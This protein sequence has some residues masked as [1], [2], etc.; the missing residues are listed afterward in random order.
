M[1][2]NR[3]ISRRS[4]EA[5]GLSWSLPAAGCVPWLSRITG[6]GAWDFPSGFLHCNTCSKCT[7]FTWLG[8]LGDWSFCVDSI[9]DKPIWIRVWSGY[10]GRTYS[11]SLVYAI[12]CVILDLTRHGNWL[13]FQNLSTVRFT[14]LQAFLTCLRSRLIS[15]ICFSSDKYHLPLAHPSPRP[16]VICSAGN[17]H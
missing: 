4:A 16:S 14:W 8:S 1:L 13:F 11:N 15:W 7:Y 5:P 2:Q 12:L 3:S 17:M 6:Y 9:Y 10:R